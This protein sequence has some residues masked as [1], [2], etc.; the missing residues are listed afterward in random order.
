MRIVDK[1]ILKGPKSH[2]NSRKIN[3]YIKS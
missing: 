2:L 1:Y 3:L